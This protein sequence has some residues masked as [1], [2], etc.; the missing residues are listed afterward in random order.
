MHRTSMW[1][2]L[3]GHQAV[4]HKPKKGL[5]HKKCIFSP[6]LSLRWTVWQPY[7]LH[8][9]ILLTQDSIPEIFMKKYWELVELENEVF[10]SRPFW[11][12]LL[13]SFF[14]ASLKTSSPFIWGIIYFCTLD[15]FFR[16][17]EKTSSEL[18][19]TTVFQKQSSGYQHIIAR[20]SNFDYQSSIHF[21]LKY[22][23]L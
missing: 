23:E 21:Y 4:R 17:L 19:H 10:L 14:F 6:I 20:A 22:T 12:F 8:H 9:L 13:L 15:G 7:R 5:K 11:I 2:N 16:I 1:L 18:M 3:Y